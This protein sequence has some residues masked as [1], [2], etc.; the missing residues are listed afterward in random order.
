MLRAVLFFKPSSCNSMQPSQSV[1]SYRLH[2]PLT[3][4]TCANLDRAS[5][6]TA[7]FSLSTYRMIFLEGKVMNEQINIFVC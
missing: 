5:P 1:K 4:T 2:R 6:S 7:T 3:M